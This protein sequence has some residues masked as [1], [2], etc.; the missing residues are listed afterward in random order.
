M[1]Q[2]DLAREAMMNAGTIA[3]IEAGRVAKS[4]TRETLEKLAK[5][6]R[7]SYEALDHLMRGSDTDLKALT[8]EGEKIFAEIKRKV[9][10]GEIL[11][12]GKPFAGL[13][14]EEKEYL[15]QQVLQAAEMI[16]RLKKQ[17]S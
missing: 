15:I 17:G 10:G 8:S 1:S 5:G 13:S 12:S 11:L 4:P 16:Q 9:E 6:L 3:S 14:A 2:R 7:V